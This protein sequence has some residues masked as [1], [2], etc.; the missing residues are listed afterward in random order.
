[1]QFLSALHTS[2]YVQCS[3]EFVTKHDNDFHVTAEINLHPLLRSF[4]SR[5]VMLNVMIFQILINSELK[6]MDM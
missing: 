5:C 4:Y 3:L 2:Q 6:T 1:M